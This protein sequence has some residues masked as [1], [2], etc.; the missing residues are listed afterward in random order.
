MFCIAVP[1]QLDFKYRAHELKQQTT[2]KVA[3]PIENKKKPRESYKNTTIELKFMP[4]RI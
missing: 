2:A 1:I 4:K 3:Q